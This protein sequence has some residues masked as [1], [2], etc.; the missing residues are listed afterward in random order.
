MAYFAQIDS[1]IV[2]QVIVISDNDCNN[3][4]FPESEP[5]GQ[6]Y[7]ASLNIDG[8]WLQTSLTGEYRNCYAGIGYSFDPLLGQYGEF[9]PP[10]LVE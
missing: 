1:N 10:T 2:K 3:L 9:V 6:T 7:I 4:L 8:V 5:V